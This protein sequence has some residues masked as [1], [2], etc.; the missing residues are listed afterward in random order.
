[1]QKYFLSAGRPDRTKTTTVVGIPL[2][3]HSQ[4]RSGRMIKAASKIT[5]L[6]HVRAFGPKT[7]MIFMGW[8][9][10]A[11]KKASKQH[12][13]EEAKRLQDEKDEW[14]SGRDKMHMDYLNSRSQRKEDV[15]P[16]GAYIVDCEALERGW[17]DIADGLNL[18]IHLTDTPGVF[19]A[20]FDFGALEGVMIIC[21]E[22]S[23]LDEYYAQADRD[24][25]SDWNDSTDEEGS[26]EETDE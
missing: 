18:D 6:H 16:V 15:T 3:L 23:T 1:M 20:E 21:S 17:P 8:D 4:Y 10:A 11:V 5:S 14:E 22:N 9:E 19:K 12:S 13:V 26:E 24:D 7:Q 25:E 2:D